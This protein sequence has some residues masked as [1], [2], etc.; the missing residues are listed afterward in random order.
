MEVVIAYVPTSSD[1]KHRINHNISAMRVLVI[2]EKGNALGT[3]SRSEAIRQ[4]EEASLDLVEVSPN[5]DPPV[6]R[7]MDYG[8]FRYEAK[9][10]KT[11]AKKNQKIV[12]I[13]E[14]K[15]TPNIG[16]HDYQF[17]LNSLRR[18]IESGDKVK[19]TLRFRGRELSH[20]D[21]GEKLINRVLQEC[22]DIAKP[23]AALKMEGKQLIVTLCPIRL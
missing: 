20:K 1:I 21:L 11:E 12:D 3:L 6:C 4:A 22:E 18:F 5:S 7:I 16:K 23:E 9:K 14:V 19:V 10:K 15:L 17:K 2:D 13:K 8:K